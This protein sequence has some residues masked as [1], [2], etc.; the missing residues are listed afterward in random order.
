MKLRILQGVNFGFR[1]RWKSGTLTFDHI[2][3]AY[4]VESVTGL[5]IVT[6]RKAKFIGFMSLSKKR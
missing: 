1:Y 3:K 6:T 4:T 2:D 5:E